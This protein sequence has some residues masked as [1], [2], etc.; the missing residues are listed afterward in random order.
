MEIEMALVNAVAVS[1]LMLVG[2]PTNATVIWIHTRSKS[3]LTHNKFPLIFAAIDLVAILLFLPAFAVVGQ[4]AELTSP[5]MGILFNVYRF[6][7]GWIANAY[8]STL[9]L[10]SADKLHA[11]TYPF[12]YKNKHLRFVKLAVLWAGPIDLALSGIFA[13]DLIDDVKIVVN[14]IYNTLFLLTFLTTILLYVIIV[15]RIIQS[16][17]RMHSKIQPNNRA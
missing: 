16:K 10:A 11:V 2:V 4:R 9:L 12:A 7:S 3:H 13:T 8:C 17:R 5:E 15:V 1:V 6:L 14:P